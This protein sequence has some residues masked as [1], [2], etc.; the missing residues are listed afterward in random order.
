MRRLAGKSTV[1][2]HAHM[3]E[4]FRRRFI[5]SLVLHFSGLAAFAYNPGLF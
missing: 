4:D 2:I 5:V 3:L 1:T